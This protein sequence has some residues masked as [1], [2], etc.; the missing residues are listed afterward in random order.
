MWWPW[1]APLRSPATVIINDRAPSATHGHPSLHLH[2]G[3]APLTK[4][5]TELRHPVILGHPTLLYIESQTPWK[6][7]WEGTGFHIS[8]P[9]MLGLKLLW[10]PWREWPKKSS[11]SNLRTRLV[12]RVGCWK[13]EIWNIFLKPTL[14]GWRNSEQLEART[15]SP[16]SLGGRIH[17][18]CTHQP[19]SEPS[20]SVESSTRRWGR[21]ALQHI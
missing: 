12:S 19:E 14:E 20:P 16:L 17:F 21:I 4:D 5:H 18:P 6:E 11:D 1:E 10:N 7:L 2:W 3:H 8:W 15:P 9:L 13:S